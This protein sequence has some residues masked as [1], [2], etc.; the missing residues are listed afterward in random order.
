[1][2]GFTPISIDGVGRSSE[3]PG[4]SKIPNPP[5][6]RKDT[7]HKKLSSPLKSLSQ[8]G[9]KVPPLP[10]EDRIYAQGVQIEEMAKLFKSSISLKEISKQSPMNPYNF[11]I[12]IANDVYMANFAKLDPST[13]DVV[14][15]PGTGVSTRSKIC[16]GPAQM[17]NDLQN[18][19]VATK[20]GETTVVANEDFDIARDKV[21]NLEAG[22]QYLNFSEKDN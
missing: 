22:T 16:Y 11:V 7:K 5:P 17:F 8:E 9:N 20:A 13:H 21:Y 15:K 6:L 12:E 4:Q 19:I 3:I 1:M 10:L 2:S 14:F 18:V